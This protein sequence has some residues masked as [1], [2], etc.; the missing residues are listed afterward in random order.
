MELDMTP[1]DKICRTSSRKFLA[2]I[3]RL[4]IVAGVGCGLFDAYQ[5]FR[6]WE[7]EKSDY[8]RNKMRMECAAKVSDDWLTRNTNEFGNVDV[9]SICGPGTDGK[10]FFVNASEIYSTRKGEDTYAKLLWRKPYDILKSL[11]MATAALIGINL[12]GA[13]ILGLFLVGRWIAFGGRR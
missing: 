2:F 8:V 3:F 9:A 7:A 1:E 6:D 12:I 5:T 4:S 11:I 13:L 10:T